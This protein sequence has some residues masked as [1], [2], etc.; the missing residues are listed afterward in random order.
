MLRAIRAH[1]N[2]AEY[3]PICLFAIYL[4]EA[5][6]ANPFFVHC[7]GFSLL[8]GRALHAYGISQV[9]ENFKFRVS[10]MMFTFSSLLGSAS[11]L[12][13]SFFRH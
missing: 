9:N 8:L 11:Y 7:L 10:G 4:T 3:V 2:F 13:I 1:S 6:G 12:I 5:Q